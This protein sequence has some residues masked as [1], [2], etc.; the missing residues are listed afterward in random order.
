VP[1]GRL[2]TAQTEQHQP[3]RGN[4]HVPVVVTLGPPSPVLP[5]LDEIDRWLQR[6]EVR[7]DEER[8]SNHRTEVKAEQHRSQP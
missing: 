6:V 2:K 3:G 8:E 5:D 4:V 7:E 1:N